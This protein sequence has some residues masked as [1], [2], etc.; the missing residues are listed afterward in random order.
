MK[1]WKMALNQITLNPIALK[2]MV[3]RVMVGIAHVLMISLVFAQPAFADL[4]K[5]TRTP[6]YQDIT[7]TL[8]TLLQN[9]DQSGL[10]AVQLQQKI[11]N[12]R[13]Q[14]YLLE[15]SDNRAQ[16]RNQTGKT[17][18][19]YAKSKKAPAIAPS[20]LYFLADGQALDDD[21]A[22]T[23]V[24]LPGGTKLALAPNEIQDLT[25]AIVLK[26]LPGTQLIASVNPTTNAVELNVPTLSVVNASE[27]GF[28]GSNLSQAEIDAQIPNAPV[29]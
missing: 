13:W 28:E 25:E 27:A 17:L 29:D 7:Q 3:T 10:D 11:T 23:S 26:V 18:A 5:F 9:P 20:T 22:C 2:K 12:L 8:E 24:L 16:C 6:E 19:I 14:K 15:T 4:G 1:L 21:W